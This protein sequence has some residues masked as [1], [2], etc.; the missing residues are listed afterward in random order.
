MHKIIYSNSQEKTAHHNHLDALLALRGLACLMVVIIHCSPPRAS[1]IYKGFDLSWLTFSHGAVAVWI[2]FCLSGYLMG[3]A[4]YTERYN[5][6][7]AG[8]KNFWK[9]RA[10]RI[11][12]LYYFSVLILSI[13]VYPE[14]LKIE[15]W[16]YLVR[17][18]TF[19]YHPYIGSH[20]VLFNEALWSLSTEI[21][22]YLLIPFIFNILRPRLIKLQQAIIVF[23]LIIL[24]TSTFK[25]IIW[26]SLYHHIYQQMSYAVKYWYSPLI[27]NLDVFLCG[28]LV[29]I[30]IKYKTP[31][32]KDSDIIIPFTKLNI[33]M[34]LAKYIAVILLILLYLFSAYHLYSQELW[35]LAN[36]PGGWRTS[37][38]I[39]VF[40]PLTA[41]IVSFFIL[42]FESES[43][44]D[45]TR[46]EKLSF[47]AILRNPL[48]IL[49]VLGTL[50]YG[51]YIWHI[52]IIYKILTVFTSDI[53]FEAFYTRVVVTLV[54]STALATVT[55]YLIEIPASRWK[56]YA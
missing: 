11:F 17:I 14:I 9:N 16:G 27:N 5:S 6:D 46:N 28:F 4:F 35:G 18:C 54:L 49:E 24:L 40:Q 21:Q 56:I 2:F 20:P 38:T 10:I 3:K 53:P 31:K 29:N 50:S 30:F 37:M 55:Y 39:F 19:T 36:R 48:R 15:N 13:F 43:Y 52:P 33:S 34:I 26:L 45:F 23:G 8:V 1:I 12:P 42:A 41:I 22:F 32:L 47:A 51:I 44:H 7:V 25:G